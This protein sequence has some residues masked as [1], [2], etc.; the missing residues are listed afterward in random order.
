MRHLNAKG[1]AD[2]DY[3]HDILSFKVKGR[4]YSKSVE[5]DDLVL[6]VDKEGFVTGIQIFDA[7]KLFGLA[8]HALLKIKR[9]RFST[10]VEDSIVAVQLVFEVVRR[11]RVLER[12]QNIVREVA[13]PL[14]DTET[15]CSIEA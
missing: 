6:D 15:R 12:G 7:S 14:K 8:K 5:L 4:Y 10:K 9:W 11:N 13:S 2:Y 3:R 1:E